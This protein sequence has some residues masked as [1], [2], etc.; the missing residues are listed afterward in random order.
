MRVYRLATGFNRMNGVCSCSSTAGAKCTSLCTEMEFVQEPAQKSQCSYLQLSCAGCGCIIQGNMT[1]ISSFD[2]ANRC[3]AP[4]ASADFMLDAEFAAELDAASGVLVIGFE[5][6]TSPFFADTIC[7]ACKVCNI[8]ICL[9][10]KPYA[11]DCTCVRNSNAALIAA[12]QLILFILPGHGAYDIG[13]LAPNLYL[14]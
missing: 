6:P 7:A 4:G 1:D 3:D 13:C 9:G 11:T 2:S 12:Q 8:A 10:S 5:E 14:F